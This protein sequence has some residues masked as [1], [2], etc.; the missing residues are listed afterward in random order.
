MRH[1]ILNEVYLIVIIIILGWAVVTIWLIPDMLH[2]GNTINYSVYCQL[3]GLRMLRLEEYVHVSCVMI[4]DCLAKY[5]CT[6]CAGRGH[7]SRAVDSKERNS[8]FLPVDD[9]FKSSD[10]FQVHK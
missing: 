7:F 9:S 5:A 6:I 3:K 8:L 10:Y 2:E 1:L 4:H